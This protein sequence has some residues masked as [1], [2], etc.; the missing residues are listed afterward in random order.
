[1]AW[2]NFFVPIATL[3]YFYISI[4]PFPNKQTHSC[5]HNNGI[6][7]R[8]SAKLNRFRFINLTS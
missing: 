1:M 6:N 4:S 3:N 2:K 5:T 8:I 7:D